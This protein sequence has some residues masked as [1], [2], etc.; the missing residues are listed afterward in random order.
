[1]T[2]YY[3]KPGDTTF[4]EASS[5]AEA[6]ALAAKYERLKQMEDDILAQ[7]EAEFRELAKIG[8]TFV[9]KAGQ[10]DA[11]A[12]AIDLTARIMS[13]DESGYVPGTT[14]KAANTAL[15]VQC[16]QAVKSVLDQQAPSAP[17]GTTIR[18]V[19]IRGVDYA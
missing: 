2:H 8:R 15:V 19:L 9:Y 6:V 16:F 11:T 13:P 12:D 7:Y 17:E 10:L 1:M 5:E 3:Q 4:Y 14:L 18:Q